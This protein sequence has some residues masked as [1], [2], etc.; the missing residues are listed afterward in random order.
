MSVYKKAWSSVRAIQRE[1]KQ[2]WN[3]TTIDHGAPVKKGD[4]I[5]NHVENLRSYCTPNDKM[6]KNSLVSYFEVELKEEAA[7]SRGAQEKD[8]IQT[9][10]VWYFKIPK[11]ARQSPSLNVDFKN[12]DGFVIVERIKFSW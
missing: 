2:V 5:W 1:S 7:A 9:F 10:K 12:A 6:F 8:Y 4:R 11:K 3:H